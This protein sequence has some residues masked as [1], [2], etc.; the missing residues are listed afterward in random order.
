MLFKTFQNIY[1]SFMFLLL[2]MAHFVSPFID[3]NF[4]LGWGATL[5]FNVFVNF[6]FKFFGYF[7]KTIQP[8]VFRW[9]LFSGARL[10]HSVCNE[11]AWE[12]ETRGSGIQSQYHLQWVQG[13][14]ELHALGYM[15]P[16]FKKE[17]LGVGKLAQWL[18]A[19]DAALLQ[20]PGS[21]RSIP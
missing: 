2:R 5:S 21:I 13:Q 9:K 17:K 8:Q 18:R 19:L 20:G 1:W 15:R 11:S 4:Y 16:S 6:S 7:M 10:C 3:C 12:V 14:P